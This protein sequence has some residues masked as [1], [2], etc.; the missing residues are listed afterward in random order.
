MAAPTP[1]EEYLVPAPDITI[2]IVKLPSIRNAKKDPSSSEAQCKQ[3]PVMIDIIQGLYAPLT[4]PTHF[5]KVSEDIL[6]LESCIATLWHSDANLDLDKLVEELIQLCYRK[7]GDHE[8]ELPAILPNG[9][10]LI[11]LVSD[12]PPLFSDSSITLPGLESRHE[13][14]EGHFTEPTYDVNNIGFSELSRLQTSESPFFDSS[15]MRFTHILNVDSPATF[16]PAPS[17]SSLIRSIGYSPMSN[18]TSPASF[19]SG[20]SP[21][22]FITARSSHASPAH[23]TGYNGL[24]PAMRIETIREEES[25]DP[26]MPAPLQ[27]LRNDYYSHLREQDIVQPFDKELNWS[28]KGQHVVYMQKDDVPLRVVSHLGASMTAKVDQVLCRRIG[29][30]RKTVRCSRQW[31]IEDAMRE[32]YHLQ[33]LRHAHII[34]LV[35]SYLQGRS[36][37]ILMYPVAECHLGAFLE[38]TADLH[39]HKTG[40]QMD[41]SYSA[42]LAFLSASVGCLTSAVAYIHENTTKHMDIKPQNILVRPTTPISPLYWHV[43]LADFGLSRSFA[44]QDHSQTDGPTARTPR[45]CAPEVYQHERRGRSADIFSLGCVFTEIFTVLYREHPQDFAEFRRGEGQDESFHANLPRVI[46]WI[47]QM[48]C[49]TFPRGNDWTTPCNAG[50]ANVLKE[51]IADKAQVRPTARRLQQMQFGTEGT[52]NHHIFEMHHCCHR[53]PEPYTLY[54]G[55]SLGDM[56]SSA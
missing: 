31:T 32:V 41:M 11:D 55:R 5:V 13:G 24:S 45:Y 53:G 4:S 33:N 44:S 9:G 26:S 17:P 42:R 30:A 20:N 35:G 16:N 23:S 46:E 51:M 8:F 2:Y 37:S 49:G 3:R 39:V 28:G 12:T 34:Q 7:N 47:D 21:A 22:S 6:E 10:T 18:Y 25:V 40:S 14:P 38:D 1:D 52:H 50:T 15:V 36:F 56:D 27:K 54:Q 19:M 48:L 29:L 43:Y